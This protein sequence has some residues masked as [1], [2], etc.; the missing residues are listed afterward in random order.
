MTDK[1]DLKPFP[2]DVAE[3]IA[4]VVMQTLDKDPGPLGQEW[5]AAL[6]M[7]EP[8]PAPKTHDR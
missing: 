1:P 2:Q 5:R 7:P 4:D 8:E 6:G 3:V